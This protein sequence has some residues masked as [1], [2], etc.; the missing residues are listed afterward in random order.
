MRQNALSLI[1]A[2]YDIASSEADWLAEL[3]RMA[4]PLIGD[5]LGVW[6]YVVDTRQKRFMPRAVCT[7][8]VPR[9]VI[10]AIVGMHEDADEEVFARGY[11]SSALTLSERLA[12]DAHAAP[13]IERYMTS[14]GI[15]DAIC[16]N[17][18]DSSGLT[19]ALGAARPKSVRMTKGERARFGRICAHLTAAL[20]LR[21]R[22]AAREQAP[23]AILTPDGKVVHAENDASSTQSCER[24]REAVTR[25]ERAR[26]KLRSTDADAA[27]ELWRGLV[28]GR[29]TLVDRFERDG[30][31]YLVAHEN[32]PEVA[33]AFALSRRE[34]QVLA[35]A[36]LGRSVKLIAYE[37]GLGSGT[38]GAYLASA[39]AKAGIRD[40]PELARW[41][42]RTIAAELELERDSLPAASEASLAT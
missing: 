24:L 33:R 36:A 6:A 1:E 8:D 21:I 31:R 30:R 15:G 14:L 26:G 20:R 40:R 39:R 41:F 2:G 16:L 17:A 13:L 42:A 34:R 23:S 4:L 37:L 12:G 28:S 9:H 5:G 35:L 3:G 19:L 29:W 11:D 38:V 7:P 27:L 25:Q 22:L 10:D 18:S 32:Q